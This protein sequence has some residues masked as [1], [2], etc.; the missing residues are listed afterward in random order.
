M[1]RRDGGREGGE[2]IFLEPNVEE[3]RRVLYGVPNKGRMSN[4]LD[5]FSAIFPIS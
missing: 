2:G 1:F 5:G 4:V 3:R